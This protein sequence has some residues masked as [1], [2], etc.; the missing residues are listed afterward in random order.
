MANVIYMV[1]V[2]LKLPVYLKKILVARYGEV[3]IL[4]DTSLL[5]M[6]ISNVLHKKYYA[7][8][9]Y[10]DRDN[11]PKNYRFKELSA[12]YPVKLSV[13]RAVRKGF[14]INDTK[15]H[16]IVRAIDNSIREEL[17]RT[18]ISNKEEYGIDYQT[19]FLNFLDQY[20][21]EEE[22]LSYESIRKHFNRVKNNFEYAN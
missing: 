11:P 19:T 1:E 4:K 10:R 2:Q 14:E 5:G 16:K 6:A 7:V 13:N 3:Y 12:T 18:A 20:G 21:I 22:E 15:I 17:Y 8:R 9:R